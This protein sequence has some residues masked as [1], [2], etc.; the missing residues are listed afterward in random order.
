MPLVKATLKA[1]IESKL[2][3]EFKSEAV[4]AALRKELDGGG[5]NGA[6]TSAKTIYKALSN[7]K[8][9]A[10]GIGAVAG[11]ASIAAGPVIQ[12]ISSNEWS[13][14]LADSICEWMSEEIAPII[15]ETVA[16]QVDIFIKTGTVVT[17]GTAAAQTGSVT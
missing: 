12:A 4:K 7:I 9:Q 3:A 8:L 5:K 14:G 16:D 10:D 11:A 13:N 15:A 6:K 2:K 1:G 17:A